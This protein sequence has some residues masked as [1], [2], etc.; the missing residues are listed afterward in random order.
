MATRPPLFTR[1]GEASSRIMFDFEVQ[2]CT[3]RCAK[4]QRDLRPGESF[5]SVLIAE[6]AS[7]VRQDYAADEW[8]GPPEN[9]IGWWKSQMPGSGG[10]KMHWAPNEVILHYFEQ[11]EHQPDQQDMRYVLALL[12]VRRRI[13]RMEETQQARPT[14]EMLVLFCPRTELEYRVP[15]RTPS[16]ERVIQIQQELGRLLYAHSA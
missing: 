15:V 13:V 10:R 8:D 16:P 2:R 4:T 12:M 6:G 3:R 9:A 5:Y 7:V 1:T 14:G 11:L